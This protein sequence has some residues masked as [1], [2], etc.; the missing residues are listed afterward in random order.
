M[1]HFNAEYTE[2]SFFAM[3]QNSFPKSF[4]KLPAT[5]F[6]R[7][8]MFSRFTQPSLY[9]NCLAMH[10]MTPVTYKVASDKSQTQLIGQQ[11]TIVH[12]NYFAPASCTSVP[13][14]QTQHDFEDEVLVL[15]LTNMDICSLCK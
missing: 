3:V 14:H 5:S 6:V 8:A 4:E 10:S 7:T 12:S 13:S 11:S 9:F 15:R 1:Q 2:N